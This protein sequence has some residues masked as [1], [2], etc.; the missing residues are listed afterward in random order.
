MYRKPPCWIKH[1]NLIVDQIARHNVFKNSNFTDGFV[2]L[3]V[4]RR[5]PFWWPAWIAA[6][7]YHEGMVAQLHN[8]ILDGNRAQS[9]EIE[10][11]GEAT[12][13]E[14]PIRGRQGAAAGLR[15]E[16]KPDCKNASY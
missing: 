5:C 9:R 14:G 8:S 13:N 7:P 2:V 15:Q 16:E 10:S 11:V 6:F 4:V 3:V 1:E 12:T